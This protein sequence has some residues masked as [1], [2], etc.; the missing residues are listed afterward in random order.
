MVMVMRDAKDSG[1]HPGMESPRRPPLDCSSET[2]SSRPESAESG[3]SRGGLPAVPSEPMSELHRRYRVGKQIGKGGYGV[4]YK[5]E[6]LSDGRAVAVKSVDMRDMPRRKRDRCLRE[7]QLLGNLRHPHV[8]E[9]LDSFLDDQTLIIV[10]EWAAGGD[11]KRLI[12][13]RRQQGRL[14]DEPEV[15]SL[16]RP[17]A[18]AVAHLHRHRV[19]HRDLKPANVLLT[20]D[21]IV[22]VADLGLGR[23]F[24]NDTHAVDSKVGT[25]HYVSPELVRGAPYDWSGDVWSLGCV[26]YE[27]ATL[28]S[29]FE[30][31]GAHLHAVFRRI[32]AGRYP[33]LPADRFSRPFRRLARRMLTTEAGRRTT[34]AEARRACDFA[35]ASLRTLGVGVESGAGRWTPDAVAHASRG[36]AGLAIAAERLADRLAVLRAESTR[37]T[38]AWRPPAEIFRGSRARALERD[39]F[40]IAS[41]DESD[42]ARFRRVARVASWLLLLLGREGDGFERDVAP[43]RASRDGEDE[44]GFGV[45]GDGDGD[46]DGDEDWDGDE[47]RDGDENHDGDG[48]FVPKCARS[49]PPTALTSEALAV[50]T[51][52][53]S[54]RLAVAARLAAA[55]ADVA[56]VDTR[57]ISPHAL[58]RGHGWAVVGLLAALAERVF[59]RLR[60]RTGVPVRD[61][62]EEEEETSGEEEA[63]CVIVVERDEDEDDDDA[64]NSSTRRRGVRRGRRAPP[65]NE[66]SEGETEGDAEED[67]DAAANASAWRAETDRLTPALLRANRGPDPETARRR[68]VE[69]ERLRARADATRLAALAA[70]SALKERARGENA[71]GEFFVGE[72]GDASNASNASNASDAASKRGRVRVTSVA[73]RLGDLRLRVGVGDVRRLRD[74]KAAMEAEIREMDAKIAAAERRREGHDARWEE[75]VASVESI[76]RVV[77]EE[78]ISS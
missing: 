57:F 28:R 26:F 13:R 47:N 9:M 68:R 31:R 39:A 70:T 2:P 55:A 60:I 59:E 72:F 7:V 40:A 33:R 1:T 11:L 49:P 61:A 14:L 66:D 62:E 69:A 4:V 37:F 17:V 63:F 50:P 41:D 18:D 10:F 35:D 34:A 44:E 36:N 27:L 29:P 58:A 15:W 23:H 64:C 21:G 48:N 56:D 5:G 32:A 42:T 25:P 73:A 12:R 65:W 38:R 52:E 71:V 19:M 78:V 3:D 51:P 54:R 43:G 74:A 53:A 76:V 30:A 45:D 67:A 16:F 6:R 8:V 22:K 20:A 24:E 77:D 75:D 46:E